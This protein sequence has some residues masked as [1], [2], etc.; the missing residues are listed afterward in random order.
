MRKMRT[1]KGFTL[2]EMLAC[3]LTLLLVCLLCG[4]GLNIAAKSYNRSLFESNSQTLESTLT[5]FIGDILRYSTS[6]K[7][8]EPID[9]ARPE[10]KSVAA[11]TNGAYEIYGGYLCVPLQEE[12]NSGMFVIYKDAS[13]EEGTLMVGQNVYA[14]SLYIEDFVLTYNEETKRFTGTYV[15]KSTILEDAVRQCEFTFRT[16]A[17]Q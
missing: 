16:I 1:Q 10:E 13:V 9:T 7:T 17:E 4:T 12:N 8:G 14:D 2:M 5:M 6:V 15:I 11:F 3:V